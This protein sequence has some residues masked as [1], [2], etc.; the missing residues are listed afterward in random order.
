V[1]SGS[2]ELKESALWL[3]GNLL[4]QWLSTF[5]WL[6]PINAV[7]HVVVTPTITCPTL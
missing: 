3:R 2:G 5:L 6:T 4:V 1:K 7:P